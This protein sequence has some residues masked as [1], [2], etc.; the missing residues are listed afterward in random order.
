MAIELPRY[1]FTVEEYEAMGQAGILGEDT[2]VELIEGEIIQM[3]P[4]G[5]DHVNTVIDANMLFVQRFG[6]VA[7]VSIQ[8]PVRLG[9][10]N[11]PQPD[12]VLLSP[13]S[14]QIPRRNPE[15]SDTFLVIEVSDS[16]LAYDRGVKMALYAR[17]GVP[18]A[19]IVDLP[20][21]LVHVYRQPSDDGYRIVRT[22]RPG[23]RVAPEAFPDRFVEVSEFFG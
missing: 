17:Q 6:D 4:V 13:G 14:R 11:E 15:S 5:P 16:T 3:A 2:R 19:W 1:K 20:N 7:R 12:I 22:L 8:N 23:D 9:R 10:R 21:R 18:E